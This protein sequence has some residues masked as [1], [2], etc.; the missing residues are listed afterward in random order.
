[1]PVNFFRKS[2]SS[3]EMKAQQ[4]PVSKHAVLRLGEQRESMSPKKSE[5]S[6]D[7]E[8]IRSCRPRSL[9]WAPP[10]WPWQGSGRLELSP[11]QKRWRVAGHSAPLWDSL[12]NIQSECP[13]RSLPPEGWAM[14][15]GDSQTT[16]LCSGL[17]YCTHCSVEMGRV[18]QIL[19]KHFTSM[20]I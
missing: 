12:W 3:G 17:G 1:M 6:R 20:L 5:H 19:L 2:H 11:G 18:I 4:Q 8:I 14:G 10:G 13:Q 16:P 15:S 9:S 7:A